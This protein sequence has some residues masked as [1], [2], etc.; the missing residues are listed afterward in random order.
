MKK[1]FV[2]LLV[3]LSILAISCDG[4][5]A[6]P[7]APAVNTTGTEF[8]NK[9]LNEGNSAMAAIG[10]ILYMPDSAIG[11]N[12][13]PIPGSYENGTIIVESSLE[14]T[15][16]G[17]K[18]AAEGNEAIKAGTE[19]TIWGDSRNFTAKLDDDVFSVTSSLSLDEGPTY[20]I[21]GVV[22]N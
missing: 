3:L 21:N 18:R 4:N 16:K 10:E 20:K 12:N 6:T 11:E 5:T 13:R 8:I 2:A 1:L 17:F 15:Y 14:V 9:Y 7:D 19:I 22:V